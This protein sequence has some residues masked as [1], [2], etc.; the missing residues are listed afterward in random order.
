MKFINQRIPGL[1]LVETEALVWTKKLKKMLN[2]IIRETSI[3]MLLDQFV[4][5][6]N[7]YIISCIV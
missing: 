4:S 5:S 7:G 6:S 2:D 1:L 3:E